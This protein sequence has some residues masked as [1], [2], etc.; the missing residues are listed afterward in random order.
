M[1]W[2][3]PWP[4]CTP[5]CHL[6][7]WNIKKQSELLQKICSFRL[8]NKL[9]NSLLPLPKLRALTTQKSA[10]RRTLIPRTEWNDRRVCVT[11]G[12]GGCSLSFSINRRLDQR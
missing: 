3:T 12:K 1:L 2:F 6:Y 7:S 5:T 10:W 8:Y 11:L 4:L 9:T